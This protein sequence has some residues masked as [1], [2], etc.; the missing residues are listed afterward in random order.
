MLSLIAEPLAGVVDTAFVER[1]GVAPAAALGAATV[2]LSGFL[3][4]FNFLGIGTQTEIAQVSGRGSAEAGSVASLAMVLALLLGAAAAGAVW[5]CAEPAIAWMSDDPHVRLQTRRY[6]EIRLLGL[7]AALLL[8]TAFGALRG[9]QDMRTPLWIAAVMSATNIAL[10]AVLIFGSGPVPPLGIAGAAWATVASQVI[11]ATWAVAV[12]VRRLGWSPRF[13]IGR[14]RALFVVGR[15]MVIRTSVLLFFLVLCTR[16]AL[17]MSPEAGAAHQAI[18]QI[19]MLLAFLLDAYAAT[20][21][22]LVAY[23]LGAGGPAHARRVARITIGWGLATGVVLSVLLLAGES[24]VALLLVPDPAR[25]SFARAW[26]VFALT[27]PLSA[28]SFVT[29]GIHWGSGDYAYLRNGMLASGAVGIALLLAIERSG[30]DSLEWVWIATA[31]WLCVRAV[32]G[33][34]RIWPAIGRAPLAIRPAAV[35][36]P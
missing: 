31:A 11:A 32:I 14:A 28:I 24:G 18:R 2:L 33:W 9:L 10:D 34:L 27:Q 12:V 19:W 22:S 7:P 36:I 29:D 13:E 30:A 16:V 23:F 15:D 8:L 26:V 25:D 35:L 5:L 1:L 4:V 3:W 17:Q 6:L 20:A 21:Q